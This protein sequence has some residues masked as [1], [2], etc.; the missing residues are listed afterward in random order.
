MD[1]SKEVNVSS[2]VAD[3][4]EVFSN[5]DT[6]IEQSNGTLL[7]DIGYQKGDIRQTDLKTAKDGHVSV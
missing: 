5:P 6:L 4:H 1:L 3:H 2:V 7:L